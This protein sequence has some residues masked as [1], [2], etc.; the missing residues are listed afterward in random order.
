[1]K[2]LRFHTP[3]ATDKSKCHKLHIGTP[4]KYCPEL[5][6]HGRPMKQV[7]KETYLGDIISEDGTNS[8]NIISRVSKGIGILAKIKSILESVSF[9]SHYFKIALLLRESMLLNGILT[10]CESWYG[11]TDT[12]VSQLES[13]DLQFFHSLFNVPRTV[14]TAGLYLETGCYRIGTVIKV[15]RLNF[16]HAM[17]RLNKSEMLSKVFHA[18]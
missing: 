10:N 7:S 3:D 9:G 14:P 6:V 5:L 17:V 11:L 2:K 16:L 13:V 4:S 12:E 8:A 15:R 1:M 18:Q